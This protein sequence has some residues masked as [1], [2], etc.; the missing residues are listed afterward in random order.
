MGRALRLRPTL[1]LGDEPTAHQ[2]RGRV[3]LVLDV[4]R[5]HAHDGHAVPISS[6]AGAVIAAADRVVTMAG[7]RIIDDSRAGSALR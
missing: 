5:Q 3:A 2:H 4:L 6:H 7:G 1:P